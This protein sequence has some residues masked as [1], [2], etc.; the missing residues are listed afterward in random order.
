ML[1]AFSRIPEAHTILIHTLHELERPVIEGL[2]AAELPVYAVGPLP[3]GLPFT[4]GSASSA[5]ATNDCLQWL[6]TQSP[7][8]VV[9]VALGTIVKP[10]AAELHSLALG[11][12]AS[13]RPF[14][15]VIRPDLIG[16]NQSLADALPSGF[17][18][19]TVD[20]GHA[21]VVP[22]APQTQVLAHASIGVFLSHC[23]WNSTLESMLEGVPMVACPRAAEQRSN[24]KWITEIWKMGVAMEMREDGSFS[25]EAVES[26]LRNALS[27]DGSVF[28]RKQARHF[29]QLA[30]AAFQR[31]GSS[32]ANI[33]H[34]LRILRSL[35]EQNSG[36][37]QHQE[38][39]AKSFIGVL[40]SFAS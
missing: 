21:L 32:R 26:A 40:G 39:S 11:L 8:S 18:Q 13:Q 25:K 23:G 38:G 19:R 16:T 29:K 5:V 15:W 22:W 37:E 35:N 20:R 3:E 4:T 33:Q 1:N 17:L 28:F 34:F 27:E 10:T 7:C 30:R 24:A 6:D 36:K 14:L 12:E 9:Y 2:R 31:E